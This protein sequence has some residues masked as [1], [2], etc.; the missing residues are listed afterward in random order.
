MVAFF[1]SRACVCVCLFVRINSFNCG[2]PQSPIEHQSKFY[3]IHL[4]AL[5]FVTHT[6]FLAGVRNSLV[7]VQYIS[8]RQFQSK[9]EIE[10]K[11]RLKVTKDIHYFDVVFCSQ[12]KQKEEED[13]SNV[14]YHPTLNDRKRKSP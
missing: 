6:L 4:R 11:T 9:T 10:K 5:I 1:R 7:Q 13:N 8:A 14:Y 12:S 2:I 3:F